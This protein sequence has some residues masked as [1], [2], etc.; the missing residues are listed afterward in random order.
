[1]L[2]CAAQSAAG[3]LLAKSGRGVASGPRRTTGVAPPTR[4]T[5]PGG[6]ETDRGS[7]GSTNRR[8]CSRASPV[9]DTAGDDGENDR[10]SKTHQS[11]VC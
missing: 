9:R 11:S 4:T 8:I 2:V 7:N 10:E 1:M 3:Q 5:D 6:G